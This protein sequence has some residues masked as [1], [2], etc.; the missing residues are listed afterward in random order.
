MFCLFGLCT[1]ILFANKQNVILSKGR[2]SASFI[3]KPSLR[4]CM[5]PSPSVPEEDILLDAETNS[6]S[7][8]LFGSPQSYGNSDQAISTHSTGTDCLRL[9]FQGFKRR[10]WCQLVHGW[11]KSKWSHRDVPVLIW[12]PAQQP[13]PGMK[14]KLQTQ[15]SPVVTTNRKMPSPTS[16]PK[17]EAFRILPNPTGECNQLLRRAVNNC[18]FRPRQHVYVWI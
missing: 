6:H 13:N 17:K 2:D 7:T 18:L 14:I 9:E 12:F 16:P 8:F 10:L 4:Q 15:I 1:S 11:K 3:F 5:N